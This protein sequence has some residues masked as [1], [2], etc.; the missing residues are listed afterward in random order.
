MRPEP[1]TQAASLRGFL[2]CL[3]HRC[4]GDDRFGPTALQRTPH[5]PKPAATRDL[6]IANRNCCGRPASPLLIKGAGR[7]P[8]RPGQPVAYPRF[9]KFPLALPQSSG[10]QD[11]HVFAAPTLRHNLAP[12][13]YKRNSPLCRT[14]GRPAFLVEERGK[15][16]KIYQARRLDILVCLGGGTSPRSR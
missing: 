16:R 1:A 8:Q 15:L 12:P 14:C 9:W 2:L 13:Q 3:C 4:A 6:T 10:T 11:S 5:L 7:R